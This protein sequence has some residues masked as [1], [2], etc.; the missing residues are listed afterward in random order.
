MGSADTF[1]GTYQ[2]PRHTQTVRDALEYGVLGGQ[3]DYATKEKVKGLLKTYDE[4][5][6]TSEYGDSRILATNEGAPRGLQ[7][8]KQEEAAHQADYRIGLAHSVGKQV[9]QSSM[10]GRKAMRNLQQGAYGGAGDG[11]AAMETVAKL[12]VDENQELGLSDE[13]NDKLALRYLQALLA[14][15]IGA[16]VIYNQFEKVSKKGKKYAEQVRQIELQRSSGS[17]EPNTAA[18]SQKNGIDS[19]SIGKA[20]RGSGTFSNEDS[21]PDTAHRG[22]GLLDT[23]GNG[24]QS[25]EKA[26]NQEILYSKPNS[27][28]MTFGDYA[29]KSELLELPKPIMLTNIYDAAK[30]DG[31]LGLIK[32]MPE[33]FG[34][35]ATRFKTEA[36]IRAKID[37]ERKAITDKSTKAKRIE[38]DRRIKAWANL[39]ERAEKCGC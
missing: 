39:L 37:E 22:S 33:F 21:P 20:R 6:K 4:A 17:N 9:V 11:A 13:Q 24:N 12:F 2:N 10:V 26:V 35:G 1:F 5:V 36:E 3:S 16:D 34:I 27:D 25:L 28:K 15:G 19:E 8:A 14:R 29:I 38:A 7:I 18:R 30:A 32:V 31:S 23:I